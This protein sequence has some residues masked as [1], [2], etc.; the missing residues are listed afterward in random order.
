[1]KETEINAFKHQQLLY[2]MYQSEE[3]PKP[4][5]WLEDEMG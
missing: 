3:L 5:E 2:A 1:L 4:P